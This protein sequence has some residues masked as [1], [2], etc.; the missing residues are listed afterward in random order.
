[1]ASFQ[2]EKRALVT[3][4]SVLL[5]YDVA[6]LVFKPDRTCD[7]MSKGTLDRRED[8]GNPNAASNLYG[9]G[10]RLGQYFQGLGMILLAD[11]P[12]KR[13]GTGLKLAGGSIGLA[14]LSSWT[15]FARKKAIQSLRS[16]SD[17]LLDINR[18]HSCWTIAI[19]PY[20]DPGRRSRSPTSC[21]SQALVA[22]ILFLDVR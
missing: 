19:Q 12:N 16:S 10:I 15:I 22:H 6:A 1:M 17:P 7:R 9:L 4:L 2:M 3:V 21:C 14:R 13:C 8:I 18:N 11:R 20:L 5:I